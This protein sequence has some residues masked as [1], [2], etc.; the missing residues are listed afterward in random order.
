L[1]EHKYRFAAR[2][3]GNHST[4]SDRFLEKNWNRNRFDLSDFKTKIIKYSTNTLLR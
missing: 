1:L 2:L 3:L 4:I